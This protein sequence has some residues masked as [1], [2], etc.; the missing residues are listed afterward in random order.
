MN[1]FNEQMNEII[2]EKRNKTY[3]AY[4]LRKEYGNNLRAGLLFA[5]VFAGLVVL[6]GI[7]MKKEVIKVPKLENP[8]FVDTGIVV[9]VDPIEKPKEPEQFKKVTPP[10]PA[11]PPDAPKQ[12]VDDVP[13][14]D[15]EPPQPPADPGLTGTD[16]T[17]DPKIT[18]PGLETGTGG[19][20]E[21]IEKKED[22]PF[23]YVKEMPTIEGG[24]LQYVQRHLNYPGMAR[25]NRTSGTVHIA[26]VVERDGSISNIEILNNPKIGDGCEEEAIRVIKSAKWI[27]GKNN[28]QP[29]RVQLTL[30]VRYQIQ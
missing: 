15:P 2:F 18:D 21:V 11:T 28:G 10:P 5:S 30:P 22:K 17:G 12:V 24:I 8:L 23:V 29:A 6:S 14:A 20:P 3:G 16:G 19:S 9:V 1:P 13:P 7:L 25:E 4:V 26:F 27:P